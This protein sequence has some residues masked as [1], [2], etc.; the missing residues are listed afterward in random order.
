MSRRKRRK[1]RKKKTSLVRKII[2]SALIIVIFFVLTIFSMLADAVKLIP[3]L[4]NPKAARVDQTTKIYAGNKKLI[5][6]FHAEQHRIVV[7]LKKIPKH[8]QQAIIAIEDR[9]FYKHKGV[10][11]SAILRAMLEN[12]RSGKI[13]EGGST[14]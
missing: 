8:T 1:Q 2:L 9:R 11:P 13:V 3:K 10:D 5:T 4:E 6:N 12:L 14:L 7:P